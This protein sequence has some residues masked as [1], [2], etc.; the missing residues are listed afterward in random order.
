M[1]ELVTSQ[2]DDT[3]VQMSAPDFG[4]L[5][6][7]DLGEIVRLAARG[8]SQRKIAEIVGCSQPSV[9]YALQRM[10]GTADDVKAVA[11]AKTLKVMTKWEQAIAVAA[12]RGDHR[13]ARE[14]VE[15]AHSEL[16]PQLTSG[17]GGGGVTVIVG[18][19]GAPV[20]L[21]ILEAKATFRQ[22]LSL[23]SEG[24]SQAVSD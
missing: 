15:L 18:M 22:P 5:S 24:E 3:A 23:A 12:L 9:S 13:P 21:P 20:Q 8:L 16:R 1:S 14:F 19:P 17:A 11:R 4:R 2:P 7:E 6:L 10:A